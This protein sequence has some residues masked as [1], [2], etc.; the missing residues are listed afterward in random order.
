MFPAAS[1]GVS[2][3]KQRRMDTYRK[4]RISAERNERRY[5]MDQYSEPRM[6]TV[7]PPE[8]TRP[9]QTGQ[10]QTEVGEL[11]DEAKQTAAETAH[12]VGGMLQEQMDAGVHM[13]GERLREAVRSLNEVADTLEQR[14]NKGAS[15]VVHSAADRAEGVT[16]Y[17][18]SA[19]TKEMLQEANRFAREHMWSVVVGG[20]VLGIIA[21]R[22]LKAS[23][24]TPASQG[25]G[26]EG[27][28]R[29]AGYPGTGYSSTGGYPSTGYRVP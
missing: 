1:A 12:D 14:G 25:S 16:N 28:G 3:H 19:S 9:P 21:S 5:R 20:A 26:S 23:L 29:P 15:D 22:F 11:M 6:T 2:T 7:P 8:A 18:E 17:L 4:P 13:A 27:S 10:E 24:S